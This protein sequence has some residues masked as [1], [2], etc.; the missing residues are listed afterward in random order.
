MGKKLSQKKGGG[1]RQT[2]KFAEKLEAIRGFISQLQRKK[3]HCERRKSRRIYLSLEYNISI[4]KLYCCSTA[5]Q[6]FIRGTCESKHHKQYYCIS[7]SSFS[8]P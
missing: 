2:L 6:Y 8:Q 1:D 7:L 3:C 4:L 5:K